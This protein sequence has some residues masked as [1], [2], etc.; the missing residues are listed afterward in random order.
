MTQCTHKI[1]IV[2]PV[3]NSAAYLSD[4]LDSV[5]NQTHKNIEIICVNDGSTDS[6]PD[7]LKQYAE[8]DDRIIILNQENKGQGAARNHAYSFVTG[9]YVLFLDSDDYIDKQLCQK[10]YEV[11]EK[12][13]ADVVLFFYQRT[14]E[15]YGCDNLFNR[16]QMDGGSRITLDD[17]TGHYKDRLC[18]KV[19]R[20]GIESVKIKDIL[21][22]APSSSTK[23][24]NASFLLGNKIYFP[25]GIYYEDL[26]LNFEAMACSPVICIIPEI[27]YWYRLNFKSTTLKYTKKSIQDW[28]KC[29]S[30]IK[31]TLIRRNQYRGDF[32]TFLLQRKLT[33]LSILFFDVPFRFKELVV[34]TAFNAYGG[35][36]KDF[37]KNKKNGL[38]WF[39]KD[40]YDFLGGSRIAKFKTT[41]NLVLYKARKIFWNVKGRFYR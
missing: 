39:V 36:E 3:Y 34:E 31:E 7:I 11:A 38:W 17:I 8:K 35:D 4:C 16:I 40:F 25:E 2:I 18:E 24:W 14:F 26:A 1:S 19:L 30:T 15:N 33:A 22:Y 20:S 10:S 9:K 12:H 32:K 23:L 41:F 13:T 27:L 5:L 21:F 37:L 6:S 29:F 28:G